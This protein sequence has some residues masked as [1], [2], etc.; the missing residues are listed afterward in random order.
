MGMFSAPKAPAL[1]PAPKL[2]KAYDPYNDP[3]VISKKRGQATVSTSLLGNTATNTL[4]ANTLL[5]V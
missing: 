1:P 4:A 2:T 5:G 3:N